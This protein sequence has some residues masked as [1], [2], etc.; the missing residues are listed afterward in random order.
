MSR[1]SL[2][3]VDCLGNLVAGGEVH[4]SHDDEESDQY[5]ENPQS[6]LRRGVRQEG[7]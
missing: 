6:Y 3:D 1:G 4:E 7:P 5:D 2:F